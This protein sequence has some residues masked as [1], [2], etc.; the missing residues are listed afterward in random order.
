MAV[1][2][3]DWPPDY[4]WPYQIEETQEGGAADVKLLEDGDRLEFH[5]DTRP[6]PERIAFVD[7]VR[8]IEARLY[9]TEAGIFA[10]GVAGTFAWGSVVWTGS[11]C[12][13]DRHHLRRVVIWG[14]GISQ[15]LHA[16]KGGWSWEPLSIAS[17][18]PDMPGVHL[19][20]QMLTAE[21]ELAGAIC[22][23]GY[24]TIRDGPLTFHRATGALPIV[25][26]VKT[27]QKALLPAEKHAKVP[28][29]HAGERTSIFT[30]GDRYACYARIAQPSSFAGP[31]SG[32]V[33]LEIPQVAGFHA[34]VKLL[35]SAAMAIVPFAG[36]AH[37][38]PRAPQNLQPV[39]ALEG[40]LHRLMGSPKLATR[41]VRESVHSM[42]TATGKIV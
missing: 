23:E 37:R 24:L 9:Y 7:G 18:E 4:G 21:V 17:V 1:H 25:G 8:Q 5:R 26:Y 40:Y 22:R 10:R 38:D 35:G 31:W 39:F 27:H 30:L 11:A 19:Q 42:T 3:E 32:I 14:S 36:V 34:A 6:G 2:V 41:A 33:R 13:F 28:E 29:L 20:Q 16:V 15:Q 12:T